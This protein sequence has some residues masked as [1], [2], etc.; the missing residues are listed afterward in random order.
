MRPRVS[1]EI[2]QKYY[3][4]WLSGITPAK[5]RQKLKLSK[6]K[7]NDYT[8]DFLNYCRHQV[9]FETRR[10]L[11]L[12]GKPQLVELTPEREAEFIGLVSSG[13]SYDKAA[14]VMD[15]PLVTVIDYWFKDDRFKSRVEMATEL[16]NV[17]AVQAF[18]KRVVGYEYD[19]GYR[20]ITRGTKVVERYEGKGR[21]RRKIVEEVPYSTETIIE[22]IN[23]VE[24][25]VTAGKFWL[26][27]KLPDEF[28]LDG[29]RTNI[30]N[31]GKIL[32]WIEDEVSSVSD[33]QINEFNDKQKEYDDV[34]LKK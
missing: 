22:K 29:Q 11:T 27:N 16:V 1:S 5:I 10:R 31:K 12:D 13:L 33:E 24:P 28:S 6:Q 30:N 7:F 25:D 19:G 20:S 14:L 15:V 3:D 8:P 9:K 23:V 32:Q 18:Y 2:L 34:Y 21:S 17:R 26:F 4:L